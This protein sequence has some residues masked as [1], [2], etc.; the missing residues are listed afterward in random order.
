MGKDPKDKSQ[1]K[2]KALRGRETRLRDGEETRQKNRTA[3]GRRNSGSCRYTGQGW[4][5]LVE[6]RPKVTEAR[7]RV[8]EAG[9]A[10]SETSEKRL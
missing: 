7:L 6:T 1:S 10:G 3:G 9:W 4:K 8:T 2:E 5:E